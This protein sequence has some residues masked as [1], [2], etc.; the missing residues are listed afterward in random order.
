MLLLASSV[1]ETTLAPAATSAAYLLG[2][3]GWAMPLTGE[4]RIDVLLTAAVTLTTVAAL[5][6]PEP[7]RAEGWIVAAAFGI[8]TLFPAPAVRLFVA[9]AL[10]TFAI[11]IIFSQ[12]QLLPALLVTLPG[13]TRQLPPPGEARRTRFVKHL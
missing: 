11:D 13:R 2:G 1:I 5:A 7:E 9:L 4:A 6:S 3:G 12:R 8:Q 10:L